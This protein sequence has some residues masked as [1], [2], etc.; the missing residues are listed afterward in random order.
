MSEGCGIKARTMVVGADVTHPGDEEVCPS[1]AAV[2]ATDDN[3]QFKYL[4]SARLQ[5]GKQEVRVFIYFMSSVL[6]SCHPEVHF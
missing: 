6:L 3:S 4:G 2:V 5:E 1:I